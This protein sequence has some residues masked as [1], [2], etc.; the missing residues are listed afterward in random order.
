MIRPGPVITNATIKKRTHLIVSG[1][2]FERGAVILLDGEEQK[3][4]FKSAASLKGKKVALKIAPGV[5]VRVQV[6]NPDGATSAEF[7]FLRASQ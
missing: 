6:R 2:E 4:K 1:S 7:N 3:T 5:M